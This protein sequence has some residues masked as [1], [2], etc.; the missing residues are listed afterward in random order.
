MLQELD[1]S[2]QV[3]TANLDCLKNDH[4]SLSG[5]VPKPSFGQKPMTNV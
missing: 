3:Q 1:P 4:S 5:E 2:I